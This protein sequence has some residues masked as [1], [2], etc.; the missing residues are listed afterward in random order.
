MNNR[1]LLK[2]QKNEILAILLDHG[3]PLSLFRWLETPSDLNPDSIISRLACLRN[4]F[5]FSF[6]MQGD[7]HFSIF[8]PSL[9]SLIGTD[10]PGTWEAQRL[11]FSK[12]LRLLSGSDLQYSVS[13]PVSN[14]ASHEKQTCSTT[15]ESQHPDIEQFS[16]H[17][18]HLLEMARL[19]AESNPRFPVPP[20]SIKR[21]YGKA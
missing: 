1:V 4:D 5:Y 3:L 18:D 8:S 14:P 20:S 12:W 15:S 11:C 9:L 17:L 7:S 6:E 19:S 21:Y 16:S 10:F 13:P 2:S